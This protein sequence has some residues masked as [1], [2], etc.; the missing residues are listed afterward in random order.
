[1]VLPHDGDSPDV[2]PGWRSEKVAGKKLGQALC[3]FEQG[4]N[5]RYRRDARQKPEEGLAIAIETSE[6]L[7]ADFRP[8]IADQAPNRGRLQ[9]A[10]RDSVEH[11]FCL[12]GQ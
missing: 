7:Q 2:R 11:I 12:R 10:I 3:D 9:I 5:C 6:K 1:V 4:E 8:I